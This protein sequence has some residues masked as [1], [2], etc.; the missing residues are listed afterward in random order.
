[1]ATVATHQTAAL[2][3]RLAGFGLATSGAGTPESTSEFI[4]PQ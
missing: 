3:N 2:F 4:Q 1:L